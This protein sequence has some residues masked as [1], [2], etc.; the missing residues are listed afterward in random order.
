MHACVNILDKKM[1]Q[2]AQKE[3]GE[4]EKAIQT[5]RRKLRLLQFEQRQLRE[6]IEMLRRVRG[7]MIKSLESVI[8]QYEAIQSRIEEMAELLP[9]TEQERQQIIDSYEAMQEEDE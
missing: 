8:G 9:F 3:L 1:S 4:I 5:G 6:D 7:K 2:K